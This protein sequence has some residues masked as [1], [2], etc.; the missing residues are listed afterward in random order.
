M[1][2]LDLAP[3]TP[4]WHAHRATSRNA[5]D[6]PAMMG[7]SPYKTRQQLIAERATGA[8][9]PEHDSH[10]LARFARGHEIEAAMRPVA[11]R[12]IGDD[13]YQIIATDD[14]GYLSASYDGL[15]MDGQHAWE[16]KSWN[17]DKRE[18]MDIGDVPVADFWQCVQQLYISGATEL[19][20]MISDGD[21]DYSVIL[22]RERAEPFFDELLAGWRQLDQDEAD[23]VATA[24]KPDAVARH[25]ED[26]PAVYV[27][28]TG[29]LDVV[30]NFAIFEDRLRQFLDAELVREP[31]TDD[32]FA[33][34][35][36]QIKLLKKAESALVQAGQSMLAQ[37][38][39]IDQATRSKDALLKLTRDNR[40]MAEKLLDAEKKARRAE[41]IAEGQQRIAAHI[42]QI[43]AG[44]DGVRMPDARPDFAGA[45]KGKRTISS[46]R[47]AMETELA[48][49]KIEASMLA[50]QMRAG[51]KAIRDAGHPHLF[52]DADRL[53]VKDADDLDAV[54]KSRI[55][56]HKAAEEKR[57]AAEREKIRAEEQAA[58]QRQAPASIPDHSA[59]DAAT[60][61][62][63][64]PPISRPASVFGSD[65]PTDSQIIDVLKSH[66]SVDDSTVIEWLEGMDLDAVSAELASSM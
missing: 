45:M 29:S 11:E 17:A 60:A 64:A 34:L 22:T 15:T 8:A 59:S 21:D 53:A 46:L 56:D 10:T 36:A 13:L 63:S 5:S 14:D 31:Q 43:N 44:L 3:G 49:A 52:P 23:Y 65:R 54:I 51:V 57:L 20:Y 61:T 48:R 25:G 4:E 12:M 32:D 66:F 18:Q 41:I 33:T 62:Q 47:D 39:T 27:Q 50:D 55:A 37:V 35:D 7:C 58:A 16:C 6:A 40:L 9:E 2:I 38:Q 1:I 30:D 19:L 42:D 26:L 28:V 24:E